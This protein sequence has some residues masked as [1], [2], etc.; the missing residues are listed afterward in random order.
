[1]T[2]PIEL[3]VDENKDFFNG[4]DYERSRTVKDYLDMVLSF[5]YG[6]ATHQHKSKDQF[7]MKMEGLGGAGMAAWILSQSGYVDIQ[8]DAIYA[9]DKG[10]KFMEDHY[11]GQ[12]LFGVKIK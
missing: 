10:I 11:S 7:A 4:L 8:T 2:T 9:T 5:S 1:M 6:R 3:I 12:E